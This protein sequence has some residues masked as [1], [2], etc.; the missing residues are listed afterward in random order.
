M[1]VIIITAIR[2]FMKNNNHD[3]SNS[4]VRTNDNDNNK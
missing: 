2:T 3:D 1:V 4:F